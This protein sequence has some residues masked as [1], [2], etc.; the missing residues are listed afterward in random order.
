LFLKKILDLN[1]FKKK[2]RRINETDKIA[3]ILVSNAN[4]EVKENASVF[5]K[6][7]FPRKI[8]PA[9]ILAIVNERK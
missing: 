4:A 9:Y 2:K 8:I 3:I 7:G 1:D 5:L 6:F